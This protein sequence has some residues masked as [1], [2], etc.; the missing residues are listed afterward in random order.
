MDARFAEG[1]PRVV[2]GMMSGTSLDGLDVAAVGL[3][4]RAEGRW[5]YELLCAE[6]V[7]YEE[8][9]RTRLI[10]AFDRGAGL[11][12]EDAAWLRQLDRAY[13]D[14][15]GERAADFAAAYG[16]TPAL[17]ASHGHTVHHRPERKYTLQVGDPERVAAACGLPVVAD[18]RRL[19]V[20]LGGQGAPLVP[21]ADR[22]LFGDYA[23]CLNLGGFA[24]VSYEA[25]GG[26]LAY[27]ITVVN[28]LLN[29]LA[30]RCGRP[31]DDGGGLARRGTVLP[32]L[33][34]R[35][36][37]LSYYATPPPKSLG[38]EWLESAV[39]PLFDAYADAPLD[40]LATATVHVAERIAKALADGPPGAVLVS[41]GGA[42]NDFLIE[43]L[44][45]RLPASHSLVLP[46]G[47]L[48]DFKEAIAFAL[49]GALRI[50]GE[51]T[52][53]ASV[54][55]ARRDSCGGVVVGYR[56]AGGTRGLLVA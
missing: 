33:S 25:P 4:L 17:V 14:W 30:E 10:D 20:E 32:D 44:A 56:T 37:A 23:Q 13:G 19:D 7:A 12:R 22:L 41:G 29:R 55:G 52:A 11:E 36:G 21:V 47:P 27:D 1:G 24:N 26:R 43:L 54:T 31:Y 34:A 35:L 40:A 39:A 38:R 8:A 6:T 5:A 53:L 2:I 46:E 18:F 48:I 42:H 45:Q 16:L 3:E 49:L 50:R 51:A 28:G 15:L 9:W